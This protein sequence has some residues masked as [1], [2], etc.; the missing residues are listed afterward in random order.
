L[1]WEKGV[2]ALLVRALLVR[3]KGVRA[4]WEK[5]VRALLVSTFGPFWSEHFWS[6]V[7]LVRA[8][9]AR[10]L[11]APFRPRGYCQSPWIK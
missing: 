2:R 5:G 11:F 7:L 8:L 9:F 4:L 3:E 1:V 6:L 10:A